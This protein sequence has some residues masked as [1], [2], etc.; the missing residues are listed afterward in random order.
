MVLG[1][2][3]GSNTLRAC[4]MKP[5]K[6]GFE[7][8]KSSER[9]VGSARGLVAN[10]PLQTDAK[11][12]ILRAL[13]EILEELSDLIYER[14]LEILDNCAKNLESDDTCARNFKNAKFSLPYAAVA[15]EAFRVASDSVEFF[16]KLYKE[17]CVKFSIIDGETE[18]NLTRLGIENRLQILGIK[19]QNVVSIDLGGA[20]TEISSAEFGQ[21]FKFGIVRFCNENPGILQNF[22]Y[23]KFSQIANEQTRSAREFLR[24]LGTGKIVLTSGVPTTISA[25][26]LGICA[27]D[28]DAGK[29]NGSVLR[30]SDFAGAIEQ[31][32]KFSKREADEAM[33]E[34]RAEVIVAGALLLEAILSDFSGSGADFIVVDDGLREGVCINLMQNLAKP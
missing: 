5:A 11:E 10:K 31:I 14:N 9:I 21:S 15:T 8:V 26:K 7:I 19:V 1:F 24:S 4:V 18:T 27:K 34:N 20:S 2:D 23:A 3:L 29:I 17:F 32:L 16:E 22:N 13:G 6:T 25:L 33:G 28:Y 12:R 30:F